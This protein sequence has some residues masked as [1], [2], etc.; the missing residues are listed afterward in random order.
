MGRCLVFFCTLIGCLTLS[1]AAAPLS[2]SAVPDPLRSWVPWV[3]HGHETLACPGTHDGS[4]ERVCVWPSSLGLEVSRN[5][6]TFRMDVQVFGA[7]SWVVLPGESGRWPQDVK[8][9]G[10][11]IA[12]AAREEQPAALLPVGR[13]Q[14]AGVLRW[15]E[16]PQDLQLPVNTGSLT[17]SIDGRSVQRVPD[18]DGRILLEQQTSAEQATNALN[19]RTAR[20]VVDDIPMRITTRFDIA[21]SGKPR[22]IEL[23]AALLA[24]FVPEAI[25]SNLPARLQDN[26]A[27]RVQGRAGNWVVEVRSRLMEAAPALTLPEKAAEEIWSFVAHPELR[28]VTLE[29]M[30]SIDPKQLPLPDEWR[31][32]PAYLIKPGQVV[33]L[34][35]SRRGNPKPGADK[36]ALSRDIWLDFDGGGYTLR[37]AVTGQLSRSWRLEMQQAVVLGRASANGEDQP[38]TRRDGAEGDGLELREGSLRLNADSR[39]EG[40]LRTLPATGWLADFNTASTRLHLPPGWLLLHAS[41]VDRSDQ[42]WVSRWSLWDLFVVVLCTLAAAKLMG[43]G[44]A[45]LLMAALVLSWHL[46]GLPHLLWLVLL[47]LLA[48]TRVLPAGKLWGV[49]TVCAWVCAGVLTLF[50]LPHAVDQIRWSIYPSL[51]RSEMSMGEA[52]VEPDASRWMQAV[53]APASLPAAASPALN[54]AKTRKLEEPSGLSRNKSMD[55]GAPS[56]SNNTLQRNDPNAKVQT[57]PGL[58]AWRWNQHQLVWQGPVVQAQT[59]HLYMLPPWAMGVLRL[60]ALS[61]TLL[62]FGFIVATLPRRPGRTEGPREGASGLSAALGLVL[63]MGLGWVGAPQEAHASSPAAASPVAATEPAPGVLDALRAKLMAPPDCLPQCA[64]IARLWVLAQGSK[65]QLRLEVHALADVSLPLPGQGASWRPTQVLVDGQPAAIRRDEAGDLWLAAR[66][67][68]SQVVLTADVGEVASVEMSLPMPVQEVSPQLDGWTLDGL[69]ARGMASGALSLSRTGGARRSAEGGTQRDALPPF[70]QVERILH[71]GL[72]WTIET[73]VTRLSGSR[74]PVRAKVRLLDGESVNDAVVR[75]EDGHAWVQLGVEDSATFVSTLKE[76]PKLQLL[77]AREAQQIEVWTLDP[78]PLWHVVW[79]GIAP[80]QHEQNGRLT[81]QW[82]PWPGE[83]VAIDVSKPQGVVGQTLTVDGMKLSFKPGLRATDVTATANLR[84][85]QGGNH[86]VQLPVDVEFLAVSMDGLVLPLQPQGRDLAIPLTPGAHALQVQWREPRGTQ[87]AFTTTA[88]GLGA[89]GVNAHTEL[90]VASDRVVLAVGGPSVGPAVLFWGVLVVLAGV[91]WAL[92]RSRLTPLGMGAWFL[93]GLGLAQTSLLGA[94]VAAGWFFAFGYR[95]RAAV[96]PAGTWL[97]RRQRWAFN[98]R[99]LLLLLW[100]LA[101]GLVLLNAVRVGLL[102]Y[103]DLMIQGNGSS[104]NMLRWYQDRFANQADTAWVI[105]VPVWAYRLSMLMWALWLATA[106]LKWAK[107]AWLCFS[108]GGYWLPRAN[109]GA[110]PA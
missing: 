9:N 29:G 12:V 2:G 88:F 55:Y 22:E 14:I 68:V 105:S 1:V 28:T 103:P 41:G 65:V 47:A 34:L 40:A 3:M 59:L 74:A 95:Q 35:E 62:A 26:G 16:A 108:S 23:P 61:L 54:E 102:G 84:S 42:S 83:Q 69:D 6:A 104:S 93:L 17:V 19:I 36:L 13:H 20:L 48:L 33:K 70:V 45:V 106:V 37:D 56:Q 52:S 10:R 49:A 72:T 30:N 73:R 86:R 21:L 98:G 57:G 63:A 99:Q 31:A 81:P 77:S 96:P 25:E 60:T 7:A 50:L 82:K 89:A 18:T 85:S 97:T 100:T 80:I 76:L 107:W 8:A 78:G 67:G 11:V 27:M 94:A 46:T 71:L 4:G 15:T 110:S 38:I 109:P 92:A 91:A 90:S 39:I 66:A 51:E 58:P 32:Y 44:R 53:P 75:V 87:L 24:G 101:L 79:S 5:G 43:R 64:H